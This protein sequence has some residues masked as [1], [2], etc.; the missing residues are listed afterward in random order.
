MILAESDRN[1]R[2]MVARFGVAIQSIY[3]D[4]PPFAYTVGLTLRKHPE[5]AIIGLS[6]QR[7]FPILNEMAEW[8]LGH[9]HVVEAGM[10][11]RVQGLDFEFVDV[12][13]RSECFLTAHRFYGKRVNGLQAIWTD[14]HEDAHHRAGRAN[15]LRQPFLGIPAAWRQT[16]DR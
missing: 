8:V 14:P 12:I 6:M 2:D 13:A 11:C 9:G 15:P 3:D 4:D 16:A 7:S 10:T 5:I 1:M